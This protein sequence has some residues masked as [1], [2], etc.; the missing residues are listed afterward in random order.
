[1]T[2][3]DDCY[4]GSSKHTITHVRRQ[5]HS[6]CQGGELIK[7]AQPVFFFHCSVVRQGDIEVRLDDWMGYREA[8][9]A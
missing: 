2:S 4:I 9:G 5:G 8:A 7:E 1:M 3:V 6:V